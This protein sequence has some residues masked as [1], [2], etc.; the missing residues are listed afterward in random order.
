MGRLA[1]QFAP[2]GLRA[3]ASLSAAKV[4]GGRL[5]WANIATFYEAARR[6]W[7]PLNFR[8]TWYWRPSRLRLN[9]L[10]ATSLPLWLARF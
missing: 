4:G 2:R 3:S 9:W 10:P 6:V 5:V 8:V 1:I 7:A